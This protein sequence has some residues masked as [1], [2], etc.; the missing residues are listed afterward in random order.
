MKLLLSI[1]IIL[2]LKSNLLQNLQNNLIMKLP[3]LITILS[4]NMLK[5]LLHHSPVISKCLKHK[6]ILLK[7]VIFLNHLNKQFLIISNKCNKIKISR[8]LLSQTLHNLLSKWQHQLHLLL[9]LL[10][11]KIQRSLVLLAKAWIAV[12]IITLAILKKEREMNKGDSQMA[13]LRIPCML[14]NKLVL[15][16]QLLLNNQIH[17]NKHIRCK[18]N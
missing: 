1:T 5:H 3:H 16:L 11:N 13:N 9:K 15:L 14:F 17:L 10:Q 6:I 8:L 18:T 12:V 7:T 2:Q 4:N